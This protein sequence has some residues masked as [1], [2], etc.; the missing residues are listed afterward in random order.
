MPCRFDAAFMTAVRT[1]AHV[2]AK[3]CRFAG[4]AGTLSFQ[5]RPRGWGPSERSP[6]RRT[7]EDKA[8]T[9][10]NGFNHSGKGAA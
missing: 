4:V 6:A 5:Y 10:H 2:R 9:S 3:R 8:R 1:G 7:L